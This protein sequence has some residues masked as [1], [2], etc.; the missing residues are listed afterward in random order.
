NLIVRL[1]TFE[2]STIS[3][4]NGESGGNGGGNAM[5]SPAGLYLAS[6]SVNQEGVID[7]P[8]VGKVNVAG[9]T[10]ED[11]KADLD[12]RLKP[13]VRSPYTMVKLANFRVTVMGEVQNPGVQYVYN[14]RMTVY[15]AIA[16]AG[17]FTEYADRA[18]VKLVRE[19]KSQTEVV[20]LDFAKKTPI[21]TEYFFMMP[22]DVVYVEPVKAKALEINTRSLSLLLSAI[23]TTALVANIIISNSNRTR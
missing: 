9:M 16:S 15:Q 23:S 3:A 6:Y 14:D 18:R 21:N 7:L 1:S 5:F 8:L 22:G 2:E 4:F 12:E 20:Y 19:L 10:L 13:F 11:I 17:D